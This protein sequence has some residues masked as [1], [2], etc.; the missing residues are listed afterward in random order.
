M[1]VK[2]GT[3]KLKDPL[4]ILGFGMDSKTSVSGIQVFKQN[5]PS[6]QAGDNVGMNIK[7]IKAKQLKKG[8][9]VSAQGTFDPTNHFDGTVYFLS[10]SEGGRAKPILN[11]YMQMIYIDT[12][13]SVFRLDLLEGSKMIMPGEQVC[14]HHMFSRIILNFLFLKVSKFQKG[15]LVSSNLPKINKIKPLYFTY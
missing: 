11:K 9:I 3:V 6:A 12:W 13:F 10:K 4:Q 8:M 1:G 15:I 14:T 2:R 5:V 7:Q